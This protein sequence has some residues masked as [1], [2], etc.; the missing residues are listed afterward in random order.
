MIEGII[1]SE[2][3]NEGWE[4]Y[5]P[6]DGKALIKMIKR[7]RIPAYYQ[8]MD[9]IINALERLRLKKIPLGS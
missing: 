5:S 1:E 3:L 4:E 8:G 2:T 9:E 7:H 6:E